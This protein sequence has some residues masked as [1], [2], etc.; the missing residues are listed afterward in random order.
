MLEEVEKIQTLSFKNEKIN[1]ITPYNLEKLTK[2]IS[3]L[4][5]NNS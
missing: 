3:K 5:Y 4:F 2:F 1:K